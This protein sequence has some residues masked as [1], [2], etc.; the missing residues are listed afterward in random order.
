M[1]SP[2]LSLAVRIKQKSSSGPF[3]LHL[4]YVRITHPLLCCEWGHPRGWP[5]MMHIHIGRSRDAS[6]NN[7]IPSGTWLSGGA[8]PQL[9]ES[10]R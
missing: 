2:C 5:T 1:V 4:P 6:T 3:R 10:P 7:R 8:H 9:G